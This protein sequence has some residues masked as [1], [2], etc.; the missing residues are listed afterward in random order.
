MPGAVAFGCHEGSRSEYLAQY[1]FGSWGTAVAIPHHEDH[2]IDLT[3]TLMER[4]GKRYLARSPYTVQVKSNLDPVVFKDSEAVRWLI[5]HPLPLFLCV[6]DKASARLSVYH[7]FPRFHAWAN[8]TLP[9]RIELA[10]AP[11]VPQ[12]VGCLHKEGDAY[13]VWPIL[14][15]NVGQMLDDAFWE[16]I[17]EVF[18]RWVELEN[19]NLTRIR[20]GVPSCRL[21]MEYL[22]NEGWGGGWQEVCHLQPGE[23]LLR[24]SGQHLKSCIEAAASRMEHGGDLRGAALAAL[25]Y[26]HL[27]PE[28]HFSPMLTVNWTI[29]K[30]LGRADDPLAGVVR[31]AE[32]VDGVLA[33]RRAVE[34]QKE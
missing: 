23:D 28:E 25:L 27:F 22:V 12:A 33:E 6:V 32:A 11:A 26:R 21:P 29:S 13:V 5:D 16:R 10:P 34:N 7:T 8:G 18:K 15:F 3:C 24:R 20:A 1:V 19:E 30:S 2:G 31:L 17:R 4:V 9:A 14:D